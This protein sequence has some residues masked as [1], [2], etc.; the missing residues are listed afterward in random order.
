MSRIL[1]LASLFLGLGA[2]ALGQAT[3]ERDDFARKVDPKGA[4]GHTLSLARVLV[5]AKAKLA[6]H[7]HTGH[8]IAYIDA[9]TLTYT[10]QTGKVRVYKGAPGT[11]QQKLVR[12]IRPGQTVRIP[13]GQ[14]VVEEPGS[15]H[16]TASKGNGTVAI[17]FANLLPN[18]D[19]QSVS[20][21]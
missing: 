19:P 18:G 3:V 15:I 14:W 9:G 13:Q 2:S 8:Q 21:E 6:L 1:L 5:P 11:P 4:K 17:Y 7:H 16:R 10:V 20:D 12:V